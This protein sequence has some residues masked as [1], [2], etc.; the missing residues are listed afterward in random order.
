MKVASGRSADVAES[1]VHLL[2]PKDIEPNPENP[3]LIFRQEE[4]D[5]LQES[6]ADQGI[7][8]PL[9]VYK[10]KSG[11]VIL[12][13]ERRWRCSL[14]LGLPRIPVIVQ[15]EPTR[16]QNILMMFAIHNA[17]KDWDPLPT[18]YKL[19]D[20]ESEF[21]N[22]EGRNPT[23]PEL[24]QLASMARGEVRR[25]KKLLSLP[26]SYH[27][28]LMRELSKPR[29]QQTITVDLVLETTKG[30]EAL[31]KRQ[32]IKEED[33]EPLRRAIIDKYRTK[34]IKNTVEPRQLAR[35]ARAVERDEIPIARARSVAKRLLSDPNFD[36]LTAF[37]EAA[38]QADA[39][40]TL[41]QL[42]ERTQRRLEEYQRDGFELI[43]PLR[44]TLD[45]L[46]L[47]IVRA[48]RNG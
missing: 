29:S 13:G 18:A 16:F 26:A 4:L 33:E 19:R 17:R 3:R 22:R 38:A 10:S 11:Y 28:E 2:A 35:I 24:A 46:R 39:A 47:V 44:Q 9:T 31:S 14:R 23:E 15:P 7:L 12:D 43:G 36:I 20:L 21:A 8:V 48:L 5:S 30:V 27:D 37:N 40:H 45:S 1:P 34:V 6:I 32:V 42:A 41:E 25:L